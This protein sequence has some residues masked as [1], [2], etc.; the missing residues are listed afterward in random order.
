MPKKKPEHEDA[1]V[2]KDTHR[3]SNPAT[4][5]VDYRQSMQPAKPRGAK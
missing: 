3:L 5:V 4:A 1:K 2:T